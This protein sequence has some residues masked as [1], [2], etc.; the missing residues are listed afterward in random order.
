MNHPSPSRDEC[1]SRRIARVAAQAALACVLGAGPA[2]AVGPFWHVDTFN[3]ANLATTSGNHAM[4]SGVPSGTPGYATAPG[5]GNLWDDRLY[6]RGTV[7]NPSMP[8][9]VR[10]RFV[11]NYDL[12]PGLDF[13]R[14]EYQ[15]GASFALRA[16]ISGT[17]KIGGMFITPAVFD[18]IWTVSPGE[19][20]GPLGNQVVLRLRVVTSPTGSDQDGSY[21]TSGAAQ[22][23]EIQVELNGNPVS[24]ANFEPMGSSGGWTPFDRQAVAEYVR[25]HVLG[26]SYGN[27]TL[28]M[29]DLPVDQTHVVRDFGLM[30]VDLPIPYP[31][32]WVVAID[33]HPSLNW[34]HD[35][36]WV[37]V[38]ADLTTDTGPIGKSWTPIILANGGAGPQVPI[39][40]G[41]FTAQACPD[42]GLPMSEPPAT[43]LV[44]RAC[45]HAVVIAGGWDD[46]HNYAHYKTNLTKVYRKLLG[47]GYE[48]DNIHVYYSDGSPLDLD[49]ADGDNDHATGSDVDG[50]ADKAVIRDKITS[51]CGLLDARRDVLYI[52]TS[53]HGDRINGLVLWDADGDGLDA[54][55]YYSP[56][57]MDLDT[58]DCLVCRLFV[59]LDQC[60]SGAYVPMATDGD[61]ANSAV[62]SASTAGEETTARNYNQVWDAIDFNVRTMNYVHDREVANA[63][64]LVSNPQKGEGAPGNGDTFLNF[65]WND[66]TCHIPWDTFLC[67]DQNQV[68]IEVEI[69]NNLDEDH[70]YDLAFSGDPAGSPGECTTDGPSVFTPLDPLPVSIPAGE[71]KEVRVSVERPA[72]MD[73]AFEIGCYTV[74]V[75]DVERGNT[76]SCRGAL[77]D[78]RDAC[79]GWYEAKQVIFMPPGETRQVR[80]RVTNAQLSGVLNYRFEA[81][82]AG[83][84]P[85]PPQNVGLNGLPPGTPVTGSVSM[86]PPG[87][88][89]DLAVDVRFAQSEPYFY[90]LVLFSETPGAPTSAT[91][92]TI[93]RALASIG[94]NARAPGTTGVPATRSAIGGLRL[95]PNPVTFGVEIVFDLDEARAGRVT[96]EVLDTAG[97]KVR[98][99]LAGERLAPGPAS[100][101]WDRTDWRGHRVSPGLY[102]VRLVTRDRV[103]TARAIVL[104]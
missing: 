93:S 34:A 38:N 99:L 102:L 23:D 63:A 6:W 90:D 28:W 31:L 30:P 15:T 78:R 12:Q 79:A 45:F 95:V 100:V 33:D 103:E 55:E 14:V 21:N 5:Y 17:N 59:T 7:A 11:F 22:V 56:A 96:L 86:P 41:Q 48:A 53:N 27:V 13:L 8:T 2:H 24:A 66:E 67:K 25:D 3:A 29:T 64:F 49:N 94:L 20:G 1:F 62:Y 70:T 32:T 42:L 87:G 50:P 97:R 40:C 73:A 43:G 82:P 91:A 72:G 61:H 101:G 52:Y 54:G 44:G 84:A 16:Q 104:D 69:C 46:D 71:C 65:C 19:Y 35:C 98:T 60:Y 57:E 76:I 80:V 88:S 36:R 51:L 85:V 39:G 26:G 74:T 81:L 68:T 47:L 10:L 4:W 37:A 77:W 75:T 9:T 58:N 18:H 92:V 89:V 83:M